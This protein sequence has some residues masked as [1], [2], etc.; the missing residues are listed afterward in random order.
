MSTATTKLY[1][2]RLVELVGK[3]KA[4]E[5]LKASEDCLLGTETFSSLFNELEK[6]FEPKEYV[7]RIC[8]FDEEAPT[9]LLQFV[10]SL[11]YAGVAKVWDSE[12]S[13]FIDLY[14]PSPIDNDTREWAKQK[15]EKFQSHGFN[16]EAAPRQ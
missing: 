4:K 2:T 9:A 12:M 15:A 14:C 13:T 8:L 6:V 3:D 10:E 11:R 7:V 1:V 5:V 16:A